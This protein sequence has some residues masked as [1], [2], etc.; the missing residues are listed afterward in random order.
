M[1]SY[2]AELQN[3][4]SENA[5]N[6]SAGYVEQLT[7]IDC[8][9]RA[10]SDISDIS[11]L[12]HLDSVELSGNPSI[13]DFTPL[14][15]IGSL[16]WVSAWET[17]F[18]DA[19]FNA[20]ANHP[21]VAG[22]GIGG[23]QV[24][25]ISAAATMTNLQSLHIWGE[26]VYDLTALVG[27][28]NFNQLALGT[29]QVQDLSV[30]LQLNALEQLWLNGDMVEDDINN[31]V[32]NLTG[33]RHLSLA[34]NN[35]L[36]NELL[37][38]ILAKHPSLEGLGLEYTPVTDLSM[39]FT[40]G[41]YSQL[42]TPLNNISV[43][44]LGVTDGSLDTQVQALWSLNVEVYGQLAYG[45]LI[46][47]ALN[48]IYDP[49]LRQ[50]IAEQ[51]QGM[52]VSGQLKELWC[53]SR[54]VH[55]VWGLWVFDSLRKLDLSDN[56]VM[57]L[58]GELDGMQQL[59]ELYINDTLIAD[60]GMLGNLSSLTYASINNLTLNDSE[61]I[62]QL[63]QQISLDGTIAPYIE[64]ASISFNDPELQLCV[65]DEAA[66]AGL[67][68][69]HQLSHMNCDGRNIS[70]ISDI[71]Q[72]TGLFWLLFSNTQITDLSPLQQLPRLTQLSVID[73]SLDN[74]HV[75]QLAAIPRLEFMDIAGN[76]ALDNL[77]PLGGVSQLTGLSLWGSVER[78]LT[79]LT[80]LSNFNYIALGTNQVSDISILTQI[81]ALR[82]FDFNGE[83]SYADFGSLMTALTLD[84]IGQGDNSQ[85]DNSFLQLIFTHQP[86]VFRISLS[87]TA[88]NDLA[89]VEQLTRL[90]NADLSG[91][92]V[93]DLQPLINLRQQQDI[94]YQND[95]WK[96]V[97]NWI[98]IDQLPLIDV[99][100]ITTL[101][102]LGVTVEGQPQ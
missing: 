58:A 36:T 92:A 80:Q 71:G 56:P 7:H 24:T 62:N 77:L 85:F 67:T 83:L 8:S 23:N 21:S 39:L 48:N 95:D 79:P 52:V 68:Y 57:E 84:N 74:S 40:D 13:S 65:N 1:A 19:D 10:I 61:Q 20:F 30:I 96:P 93:T 101:Q 2:D 66:N 99:G 22:F 88:V 25:D 43:D 31:V 69:V 42:V 90:E 100:Q 97:L 81:S 34:Y 98:G 55:N 51:T 37:T 16:Q 14:A 94:L 41:G 18:D 17:G 44:N 91:T 12:T 70:D 102:S 28:A 45:W 59:E 63:P 86:D 15:A 11:Q 4:V 49:E 6:S 60:I 89:G 29:N 53:G 32:L 46:A 38:Q 87:Y 64:L 3:C 82:G 26:G 54:G 47:D 73:L 78:D 75:E 50:C 9:Y 27:L 72:L 5:A 76:D 33:L 35:Y